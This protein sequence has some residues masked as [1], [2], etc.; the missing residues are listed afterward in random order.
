MAATI[1]RD[2]YDCIVLGSGRTASQV[3]AT[4]ARSGRQ[5]LQL[6]SQTSPPPSWL[7]PRFSLPPETEFLPR[8]PL[9][10]VSAVNA[11]GK[12]LATV[13]AANWSARG[14]A[15]TTPA[16]TTFEL[17]AGCRVACQPDAVHLNG[18]LPPTVIRSG[19]VIKIERET[20]SAPLPLIGGV[21]RDV[22][23]SP[24]SERQA[25]LFATRRGGEVCWL[26]PLGD[27]LWNLGLMRTEPTEESPAHWLEEPLVACPALTQRLIAHDAALA[28]YP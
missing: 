13:S 27:G 23:S 6:T 15:A 2:A 18:A 7:H 9:S 14:S 8:L 17:P 10:S 16:I 20:N 21:Y 24:G 5:T 4:I 12:T 3:A 28:R 25:T 22:T 1:L 11:A 19:A 26:V